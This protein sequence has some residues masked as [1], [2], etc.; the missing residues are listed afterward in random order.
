MSSGVY[1]YQLQVIDP[2]KG[3]AGKFSQVK[4]MNLLR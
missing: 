4:K 1:L 3:G 2:A